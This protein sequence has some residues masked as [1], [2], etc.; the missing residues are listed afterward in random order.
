MTDQTDVLRDPLVELPAAQ[1]D[2]TRGSPPA[3]ASGAVSPSSSAVSSLNPWWRIGDFGVLGLWVVA[4]SF[5]IRYHEKWADEAQAWL[6]ARDL[7]LRT[8][9]F[10]ELR[11]EGSP[12]L[13]HTI[14][15]VAQHVFHARYDA[16][17]YIGMA[18]ASA[19]VALL[20]FRA[21]FPRMVRWPLAFTYFMVYQ[22]AVIAR[23]YTLLPLLAFAA[24]MLF[25]DIKHPERMTLVL[26]LLANLSLHGTVLAVCFG[27]AYLIES[28]PWCK[29]DA[30]VRKNYVICLVVMALT[31][32]FIFVILKPTPDIEEFY[33]RKELAQLPAAERA[34]FPTALQKL[35]TVVCGAFLD[36]LAPSV[37]FVVLTG[38]WCFLRRRFLTFVLPVGAMIALY[39]VVH[40]AAHHHGT[41][42][43]AAVA[44]LWIA[45]P[46]TEEQRAFKVLERWATHG[47]TAL[48]LCLCA[49]N[50]WD[51][52]VVTKREYLYPYS[53]AED[54]A[55]YL[56]S[57]RADRGPIFGFLY[58]MVGV[59]AYFDHNILANI[60]TAY[61][62]HGLPLNG[63]NL[64]VDELNRVNPEYVVTYSQDPEVVIQIGIP[65]L[66]AQGYEVVHFSD[67][68]YLYKHAVLEREVY[69]ILRRTRR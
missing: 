9:W 45:W 6:I 28:L 26:V 1:S 60:P 59:Q 27:L 29:L 18:G 21:P 63:A 20:I 55:K 48:L 51:A 12:G 56:K 32:L 57:V 52:A 65:Y 39:A 13:W 50:I 40:G 37:L 42:F 11:Y 36:Y 5:T 34:Q 41:A 33:L 43:V 47:M 49:V 4:V 10:H 46:T 7:D 44:A 31:F 38:I 53:G 68:Y 2:P 30:H 3:P 62:H 17:G 67:G 66:T 22:Y 16:I 64:N 19:G 15:W 58:G 23:P 69:F 24:A 25:K 14:L 8:I 61:F 54:A 35:T